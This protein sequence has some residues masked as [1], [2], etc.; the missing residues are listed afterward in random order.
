[1]RTLIFVLRICMLAGCSSSEASRVRG[2]P[3][4]CITYRSMMTAPMMPDVMERIRAEC[5][6]SRR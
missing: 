3:R 6:E 2:E 4:E 5:E 1:M